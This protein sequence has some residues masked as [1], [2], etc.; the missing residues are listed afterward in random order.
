MMNLESRSWR[1]IAM[2]ASTEMD[3]AKL[4]ALVEE[5]CLEMDQ[6][7]RPSIP[8]LLTVC[9]KPIRAIP[10]PLTPNFTELAPIDAICRELCC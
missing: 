1:D 9:S 5:L 10:L 2:R 6:V 7:N 3:P 4:A 8:L